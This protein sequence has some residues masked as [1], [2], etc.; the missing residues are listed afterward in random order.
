MTAAAGAAGKPLRAVLFDMD[1]VVADTAKAHA[2]VWKQLFDE[3]LRARA[4]TRG[5]AF[6]PF[7]TG[8]DYR[9]HVD[10]KPR[11]DGVA[12]FLGARGIELPYGGPEDGPDRETVCG[13]AA[14]KNEYFRA[15]LA[16]H[17]ARPFPGTLH[18]LRNLREAGLGT[19]L[20]SA[21]HN[22]PAVLAS[23][24]LSG[25]FDVVLDAAEL[26]RRGLSGKPDPAMLLETASALGVAPGEAAVIEDAVAGVAA[27]AAGGFGQIVGV[28]RHG[29]GERLRAAGAT[30]VVGD[31][32][33]LRLT[34][35]RTLVVQTLATVPSAWDHLQT[36]RAR[37]HGRRL[38]VCL[39][40]DGTLTPIVA[41]HTKALLGE[42]MRA[43]VDRL[44][45]HCA[46]AIVSGRDLAMLRRLVPVERV[47]F[48]GSHGFEIAAADGSFGPIER[49]AEFLPELDAAEQA[50]RAA[51][52]DVRGHSVERKR[53]SIAVH[54]RQVAPADE[55]AL[56]AVVDAVLRA[57][58][59]LRRGLGKKVFELQPDLPWNKGEAVQWIAERLGFVPP[60][61]LTVYLGDDITDE[62]AFRALAGRGLG[63][64]VR[65]ADAR[66][67]A[68]DYAVADTTEVHRFLDL[69]S[70]MATPQDKADETS[71]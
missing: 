36:I 32:A 27:A 3:F 19:G 7:D 58:P 49:G 5:T 50:L 68:A 69:L 2:A 62:H 43:A 8:R 29:D 24:G 60:D 54:Y 21:S 37:L 35:A 10:G 59:R 23:A 64:V 39:D 6:E 15:W 16:T 31:L 52:A 40:Y 57:H 55:P 33:E 67:T 9:A 53:F 61:A 46:V 71:R 1:G 51:L 17:P 63:V 18:L 47:I 11:H 56:R 48:A 12:S 4:D 25:L 14:R 26:A 66:P 30:S 38:F 65:S 28:D 45:R 34:P 13:L 44:A 41:D 22:A 20:F 42:E 70:A